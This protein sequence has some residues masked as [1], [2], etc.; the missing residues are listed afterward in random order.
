MSQPIVRQVLRQTA[1]GGQDV[2]PLTDH[3]PARAYVLLGDPGAG[4]TFS[5]EAEAAA[6]RGHYLR[7]SAIEDDEP[8]VTP[9]DTVFIDGLD[10][11]RAGTAGTGDA[12]ARVV[13]WLRRSG[14]PRLRLS[15]READWRGAADAQRLSA[16][17]PDLVELHL[18]PLTRDDML[19]LLPRWSSA[20]PEQF[21]QRA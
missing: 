18:Q 14:T 17:Y 1:E 12:L 7:A 6:C 11:V 4:K 21:L 15:C 3:R 16:L 5:F 2:A 8:P 13:R 10:E 19:A 9:T 20:D